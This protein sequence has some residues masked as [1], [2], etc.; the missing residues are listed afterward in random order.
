[1]VST[2]LVFEKEMLAPQIHKSEVHI[3]VSGRP[4]GGLTLHND[5]SNMLES[6]QTLRQPKWGAFKVSNPSNPFGLLLG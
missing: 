2:S 6:V 1:M 4:V 3:I 5:Q